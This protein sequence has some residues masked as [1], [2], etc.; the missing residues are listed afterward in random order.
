VIVGLRPAAQEGG[1]TAVSAACLTTP[2]TFS[3]VV[4]LSQS[5]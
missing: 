3:E 4:R 2:L 1:G 5:A